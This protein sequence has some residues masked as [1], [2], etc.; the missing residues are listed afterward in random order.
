MCVGEL[1]CTL[2]SLKCKNHFKL[3]GHVTADRGHIGFADP[4]SRSNFVHLVSKSCLLSSP[5]LAESLQ[6]A[7]KASQAGDARPS[8][9]EGSAEPA[10]ADAQGPPE[11]PGSSPACK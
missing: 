2:K 9:E 4:G 3:Q 10:V 8:P 11:E 6:V 5:F 7:V 1:I